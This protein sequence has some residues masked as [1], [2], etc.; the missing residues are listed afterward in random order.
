M[1]KK[2]TTQTAGAVKVEVGRILQTLTG[3]IRELT[4]CYAIA[5]PR[6]ADEGELLSAWV[7]EHLKRMGAVWN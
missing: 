6:L 2:W 7:D 1:R 5:S 4:E 3:R